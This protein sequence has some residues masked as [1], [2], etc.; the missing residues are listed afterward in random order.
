MH[1][2]SV[3]V[4]CIIT[5]IIT[6]KHFKPSKHKLFMYLCFV[7]WLFWQLFIFSS[8]INQLF[9]LTPA[10]WS[11]LFLVQGSEDNQHGDDWWRPAGAGKGRSNLIFRN[12][13]LYF[14]EYQKHR[15]VNHFWQKWQ[16]SSEISWPSI[17]LSQWDNFPVHHISRDSRQEIDLFLIDLFQTQAA[18]R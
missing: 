16:W 15:K 1:V 11:A 17:T 5:I 4:I 18:F 2:V 3:I 6:L 8:E 12:L 7:F 10:A 14:Q 9:P 13:N